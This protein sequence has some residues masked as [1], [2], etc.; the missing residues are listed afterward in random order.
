M[1]MKIKKSHS[2]KR[3]TNLELFKDLE[4]KKIEQNH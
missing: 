2:S 3:F 4:K 1:N